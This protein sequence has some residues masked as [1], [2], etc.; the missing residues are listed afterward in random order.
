MNQ[1]HHNQ[2]P[3]Q[4]IM[5][6]QVDSRQV[7]HGQAQQPSHYTADRDAGGRGHETQ[8]LFHHRHAADDHARDNQTY[9]EHGMRH[10]DSKHHRHQE[11]VHDSGKHHSLGHRSD[12]D[13]TGAPHQSSDQGATHQSSDPNTDGAPVSPGLLDPYRVKNGPVHHADRDASNNPLDKPLP[14]LPETTV[15]KIAGHSILT[16]E[17]SKGHTKLHKEPKDS[18]YTTH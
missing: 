7:G 11:N 14:D 8:G 12:E 17:D 16:T 3:Q 9:Q 4:R 13:P 1:I 2:E 6:D 5:T 15:Q 10:D 18:R